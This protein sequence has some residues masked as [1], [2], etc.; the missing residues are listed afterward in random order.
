VACPPR[1]TTKTP[2]APSPATQEN[3]R[4]TETQISDTEPPTHPRRKHEGTKTRRAPTQ[5][6]KPQI[7]Q[8]GADSPRE[9]NGW[10]GLGRRTTATDRPAGKPFR[11]RAFVTVSQPSDLRS[12][13]A[14]SPLLSPII[15]WNVPSLQTGEKVGGTDAPAARRPGG[16][17]AVTNARVRSRRS[18][19]RWSAIA[20]SPPVPPSN[21]DT[22]VSNQQQRLCALCV[23]AV[24]KPD[25][26]VVSARPVSRVTPPQS[27]R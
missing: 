14:A 5:R 3:H 15:K 13:S 25:A 11:K 27:V 26:W 18:F 1:K 4:G 8:I 9:F 10:R 2:K 23:F 24:N 22:A 20:R 16:G 21:Y 6:R 19:P 7:T 12:E 17:L